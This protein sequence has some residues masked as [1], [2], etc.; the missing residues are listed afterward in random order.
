MF[1]FHRRM[2]PGISEWLRFFYSRLDRTKRFPLHKCTGANPRSRFRPGARPTRRRPIC[3]RAL[4]PAAGFRAWSGPLEG[5]RRVQTESVPAACISAGHQSKLGTGLSA[6][7]LGI[8]GKVVLFILLPA[9]V[10][11][12]PWAQAPYYAPPS[13]PQG[14]PSPAAGGG[15][16][17]GPEYAFRPNLTN[18]EYGRCLQL[19][20]HWRGMWQQYYDLYQ[21]HRMMNPR[22]PAYRRLTYHLQLLRQQLDAAWNV[23]TSRC[24]HF[25][26]PRKP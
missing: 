8:F 24:I 21:Q 10:P 7:R 17:K 12:G 4:V 26:D 3:D 15:P 25:P 13:M 6:M 16:G 11:D 23:F 9:F 5:L 19:E 14:A 1:V 18:P 20:Q 2:L 22:N